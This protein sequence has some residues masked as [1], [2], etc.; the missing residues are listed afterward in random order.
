MHYSKDLL[1]VFHDEGVR[2]YVLKAHAAQELIQAVET[3][4]RGNTF[5]HS[6]EGMP[7]AQE[8]PTYSRKPLLLRQRL[9]AGL[10]LVCGLLLGIAQSAFQ[11]EARLNWVMPS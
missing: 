3:L 9:E 4:L 5:F 2:G 6:D 10:R 7:E 8:R 1:R 11:D